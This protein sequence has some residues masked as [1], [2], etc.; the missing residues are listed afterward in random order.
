MRKILWNWPQQ[1]EIISW[2]QRTQNTGY[3]LKLNPQAAQC[4]LISGKQIVSG[5]SNHKQVQAASLFN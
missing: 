3:K 1:E 2:T 5:F 4:R